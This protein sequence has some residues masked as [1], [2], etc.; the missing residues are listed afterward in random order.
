MYLCLEPCSQELLIWFGAKTHSHRTWWERGRG[1]RVGREGEE[2]GRHALCQGEAVAL[3][4]LRTRFDCLLTGSAVT[5]LE[6]AP[7]ACMGMPR[8]PDFSSALLSPTELQ[9][10]LP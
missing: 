3:Q 6:R 1:N 7:L 9:T 5:G 2:C 8:V 10:L 4:M